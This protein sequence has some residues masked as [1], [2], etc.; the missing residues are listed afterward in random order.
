[1]VE[2]VLG[3]TDLQIKLFTAIGQIL[4]AAAVGLIAWRQWRTAQQQADTARKKLVLDLFDRRIV[5]FEQLEE[6]LSEL[7]KKTNPHLTYI[8]I[9]YLTGKMGWAFG[10]VLVEQFEREVL[11]AFTDYLNADDAVQLARSEEEQTRAR[12]GLLHAMEEL[13]NAWS[14][15][16][17]IFSNSLTLLD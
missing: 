3:M 15:L 9:H 5:L 10:P 17:R 6:L 4:V 11:P 14:R 1:M 12:E 7:E 13:P 16:R 2:T 8:Q